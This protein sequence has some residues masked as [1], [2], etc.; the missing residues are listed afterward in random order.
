[1]IGSKN[2]LSDNEIKIISS[3]FVN[4]TVNYDDSKIPSLIDELTQLKNA[5][6]TKIKTRSVTASIKKKQKV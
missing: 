4:T 3:V 2:T 1:M 5:L 6:G